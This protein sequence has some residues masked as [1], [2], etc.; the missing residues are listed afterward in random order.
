MRKAK[1]LLGLREPKSALE[2][3]ERGLNKVV[4]SEQ[5]K[6]LIEDIQQEMKL[7]LQIPENSAEK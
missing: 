3:L 5:L 1:A 4:D 6:Y 7:D 2:T